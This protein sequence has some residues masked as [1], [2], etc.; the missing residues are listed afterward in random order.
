M[1]LTL[2]SSILHTSTLNK[3]GQLINGY[4]PFYNLCNEDQCISDCSTS[5]DTGLNFSMCH[6]VDMLVQE[7]YDGG[8]NL[9]LNDGKNIPKII[10]SRFSVQEDNTFQI[11]DRVGFKDANLYEKNKFAVQSS[12]LPHVEEILHIQYDGLL[13]NTGTLKCGVYTFYFKYADQDN[14]NPLKKALPPIWL[15]PPPCGLI[16]S[17]QSVI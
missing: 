2:N 14:N 8:V 6:P 4:A 17:P 7:S 16:Q 3:K 13:E 15:L 5:G 1:K 11:T 12:L 10:N 9:I